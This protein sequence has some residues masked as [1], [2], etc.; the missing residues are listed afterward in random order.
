MNVDELLLK[1]ANKISTAKDKETATTEVLSE[2]ESL[3]YEKSGQPISNKDK[4]Y[5]VDR[6]YSILSDK[7][8]KLKVLCEKENIS[9]LTMLKAVSTELAK[10]EGK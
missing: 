9:Y 7:T 4:K 10:K 5:I 1:Y 6:L 3:I 2:I 8:K